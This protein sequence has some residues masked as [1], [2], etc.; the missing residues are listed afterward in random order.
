M[1]VCV[2]VCVY[3]NIYKCML[4]IYIYITSETFIYIRNLRNRVLGPWLHANDLPSAT[5][6]SLFGSPPTNLSLSRT[7]SWLKSVCV[8]FEWRWVKLLCQNLSV[9]NYIHEHFVDYKRHP[10]FEYH[11]LHPRRFRGPQYHP[12][13]RR[14]RA[15]LATGSVLVVCRIIHT[16]NIQN[17][18]RA[19]DFS[20]R[21]SACGGLYMYIQQTTSIYIH[22]HTHTTYATQ[23]SRITLTYAT[24][25]THES[26]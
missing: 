13:I 4:C 25:P 24:Q 16:I 14:P 8:T 23:P 10:T 2:C 18:E 6:L 7:W 21:S 15:T 5:H 17:R 26:H 22:I 20:N 11:E 19:R 3:I 1:C 12:C 9:T